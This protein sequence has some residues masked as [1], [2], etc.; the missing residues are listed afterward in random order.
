MSVRNHEIDLSGFEPTRDSVEYVNYVKAKNGG[1]INSSECGKI[2]LEYKEDVI[3][4]T[5][6]K[7]RYNLAGDGV[8]FTDE[9]K[10]LLNELGIRYNV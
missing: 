7:L 6:K 2:K 9:E 5:A 8:K 10:K 1:T 4:S 3:K